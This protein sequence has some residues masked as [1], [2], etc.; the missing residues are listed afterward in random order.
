MWHSNRECGHKQKR[1]G[2]LCWDWIHVFPIIRLSF[3][4]SNSFY[5]KIFWGLHIAQEHRKAGLW[6]CVQPVKYRPEKHAYT[7]LVFIL[8]LILLICSSDPFFFHAYWASHLQSGS[9]LLRNHPVPFSSITFQFNQSSYSSQHL[10]QVLPPRLLAWT[11]QGWVIALWLLFCLQFSSSE[12]SQFCSNPWD[13]ETGWGPAM[14]TAAW[15]PAV[16]YLTSSGLPNQ[17]QHIS[18]SKRFP[19]L[20]CLYIKYEKLWVDYWFTKLFFSSFIDIINI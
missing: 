10:T 15:G 9:R 11:A 7:G 13:R 16:L 19:R 17:N 18:V 3:M 6:R 2:M 8:P 4:S 12:S 14:P 20:S 1:I 5:K